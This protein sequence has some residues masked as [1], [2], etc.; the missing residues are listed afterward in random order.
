MKSAPSKKFISFMS[1]ANA[2]YLKLSSSPIDPIA[3]VYPVDRPVKIVSDYHL[4]TK[5]PC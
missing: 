5:S 4:Y 3:L 2:R 1:N